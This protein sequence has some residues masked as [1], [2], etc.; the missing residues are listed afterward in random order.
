MLSAEGEITVPG[1]F[2][3]P[4]HDDNVLATPVYQCDACVVERPMFGPGTPRIRVALTF[5]IGPNGRPYDPVDEG[6]I[7]VE[8]GEV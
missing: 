7:D 1:A 6:E 3:G 4:V 2:V 8:D 5:I